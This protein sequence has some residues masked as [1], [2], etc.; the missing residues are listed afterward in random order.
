MRNMI[1]RIFS[2]W[3]QLPESAPVE[4]KTAYTF[5]PDDE[6][7]DYGPPEPSEHENFLS[8]LNLLT[9]DEIMSVLKEK[10]CLESINGAV[11]PPVI[12]SVDVL[13]TNLQDAAVRVVMVEEELSSRVHF[14]SAGVFNGTEIWESK[15]K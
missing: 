7:G 5:K 1:K 3:R 13:T 6:K 10:K 2:G 9:E 8:F 15:F 14:F 11:L 4:K 12:V